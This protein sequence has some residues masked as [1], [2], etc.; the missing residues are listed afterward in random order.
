MDVF[1]LRDKIIEA[2]GSFARSFTKV[3][4]EDIQA[5][6]Q[7]IYGQ[8][9]FWQPPL[10]QINPRFKAGRAID[11]LVATGVLHA[12]SGR[13]FR[14][15]GVPYVLHCHQEQALR[16]A[17]AGRSYVVTTGTGSGKS[18][19]Y[20]LPIVDALCRRPAPGR[21]RAIIV[22]PMNALVNSQVATLQELVAACPGGAPF[23]FG[24]YTGQADV[25]ERKALAEQPPDILLTNFMMLEM[26]L[27]RRNATDQV[28]L[29]A[30]E[31]LEFLVLDE[32]HSYRG[33]QGA[34]V[35]MLVRRVRHLLGEGAQCIGTSATM[36]SEGDEADR[37]RTVAEAASRLFGVTIAPADVIGE[38]LEPRTRGG[39]PDQQ[40]LRA[41]LLEEA[42]VG[43]LA[44][45]A[46]ARWLE[47]ELGLDTSVV[48]PRRARPRTLEE[49]AEALLAATGWGPDRAAFCSARLRAFLLRVSRAEQGTAPFLAFRFHQFV[50]GADRLYGTLEAPGQRQ[51]T[52]T[53][54]LHLPGAPEKP[55]FAYHFCRECGCEFLPVLRGDQ[56]F[57]PR[58]IADKGADEE[59]DGQ[60][61]FGF[62][63]PDAPGGQPRWRGDDGDLPSEWLEEVKSKGKG[64]SG[65]AGLVLRV[66][67]HFRARRPQALR[68]D[69]SG[70]EHETGLPG[71]L[72]QGSF[73]FCPS[74]GHQ[75][76]SNSDKIKLAMLGNEGRSS[77]TNVL[78]IVTLDQLLVQG[79]ADSERKLLGFTD[80]RQ[81]ASLQA[82]HFNDFNLILKLRGAMLAALR[83]HPQ[84]LDENAL[85]HEVFRDLGFE[86][87]ANQAEW[88]DPETKRY[89]DELGSYMRELLAYRMLLDQ[90]RGWRITQPNL[91][92]LGL[93]RVD[94]RGL[95][96]LCADERVFAGLALAGLSPAKRE[97]LFR[98]VFDALRQNVCILTRVLGQRELE[99]LRNYSLQ[100][101]REPWK[102]EE[103][104]RLES[105]RLMVP[106][107]AV[108]TRHGNL[109]WLSPRSHLM[110]RLRA[111]AIWGRSLREDEGRE[112][113]DELLRL[114]VAD[115]LLDNREQVEGFQAYRLKGHALIWLPGNGRGEGQHAVDNAYF[116][117]LYER[118][119]E[120]LA[121]VPRLFP[122]TAR[123]H[124][125]QVDAEV[126]GQREADFTSGQLRLLF[127]SP[128]MELGVDI[129][130]LSTVFLRNVPPTPANYA[131]RGGRAGR[132][133][134]PALVLTYCAALSPHDQ[135]FYNRPEAMVAGVVRRPNLDLANEELIA[136]HLQ[137]LW[138][139]ITPVDLPDSVVEMM[140]EEEGAFRLRPEFRRL[141]DTP[142]RRQR[143]QMAAARILEQMGSEL[144]SAR[145]LW[146]TPAWLERWA[147]DLVARFDRAFDRW[148]DLVARARAEL[149][150]NHRI[151]LHFN[152]GKEER[153][154]AE[155]Q[156]EE[157]GRQLELL[158]AERP[159]PQSE[160]YLYRYLAG[161][162]FLPGYNFPRLPLWAFI[163]GQTGRRGDQTYLTRPR[164]LAISEFGPLSQIYHE[165]NRYQVYR[166]IVK[167]A[168]EQGVLTTSC[169]SICTT[170]GYGHFGEAPAAMPDLCE[171]CGAALGTEA[172]TVD[173][174]LHIQNVSTR[175]YHRINC[176]E[177]E[178]LRLGY[179]V[180][181]AIRFAVVDQR[182]RLFTR[183][184]QGAAVTLRYA[185]GAVVRRINLGWRR[186]KQATAYGFLIES[187]TGRWGERNAPEEAREQ[188][189][190]EPGRQ[191]LQTQRVTPYVEDRRNLLLLHFEERLEPGVFLGVMYALKRGIELEYELEEAELVAES[192]PNDAAPRT[193]LFYEAAEGGAGV[194]SQVAGDDGA[195]RRVAA[196]AIALCHLEERD[197][198]LHDTAD[199]CGA[200]C[201]RCLL[202]YYNQPYHR[203]L[204][205]Q[206]PEFQ[207]MLQVFAQ[208]R[209][210][211]TRQAAT[212]A[213]EGRDALARNWLAALRATG[214]RDP[215]LDEAQLQA[216]ARLGGLAGSA[217][218]Y[219]REAQ[220][221]V[222]LGAP[223]SA[224][225]R[226]AQERQG[227]L[228]VHFPEEASLWPALWAQLS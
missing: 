59:D 182:P 97:R 10:L 114:G 159:S 204:N 211:V 187:L 174:L 139:S 125:A 6:L 87:A 4:A 3:Q 201:Y 52:V 47:M 203:R 218:F 93:M 88:V 111:R 107:R 226:Q 206:D 212:T 83:R 199:G 98:L 74:C 95:A 86:D 109:F 124:T 89:R 23:R 210:G 119:A 96:A 162:G 118:V 108:R 120:D 213:L 200:A 165:G 188:A 223:P 63:M 208:L 122:I 141:L 34:D 102:L 216:H 44:D 51:F 140:M 137:A 8:G 79:V 91:E 171:N 19:T 133:G 71:W 110:R 21:I 224:A 177:E 66:K 30:A 77:A 56:G 33:R 161:E 39:R 180:Q 149:E 99:A 116:R 117:G 184:F 80:N 142:E 35:A 196:R 222:Y 158:M 11:E 49:A 15:D 148:R 37:A 179:E 136:A 168:L 121:R 219:F 217:R 127:C 220:I 64:S 129:R 181:T 103:D 12:G 106:E 153:K 215:D 61:R 192:L 151:K 17:Q 176:E 209:G 62:F 185:P 164:F 170:C 65:S 221:F 100:S 207:R 214:R 132:A 14:R 40:A 167:T 29:A 20:F 69:A 75:S 135:Y 26:M 128:T 32:L 53:P 31:G 146:F 189:E 90:R 202:S 54:Q 157:A 73:R 227:C 82:G 205:R 175:P 36:S 25:A 24:A 172:L 101:F 154:H 160:F 166:A 16:L 112:L 28:L 156:Y 72:I 84:G 67:A 195:L 92:Q 113:L 55:F 78:A 46:L 2:Y 48:P 5:Y 60:A 152:V 81:D 57:E 186:R 126:R 143:T 173:T 115:G 27:T 147:A 228:A 123:E 225:E 68:L 198:V 197:G 105:A 138:L 104:E 150:R 1:E 41:A 58:D 50:S 42:A 43:S 131:Q 155:Q 178:R 134:Q 130:S 94:Y 85:V 22:Y 163:P 144:A 45:D 169:A 191:P 18:M 190:S 76:Q 70:R 193:M 194:L 9:A 145:E 7:D 13:V 38:T 183:A